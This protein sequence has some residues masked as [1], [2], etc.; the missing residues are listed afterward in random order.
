MVVLFIFIASILSILS[1]IS[2]AVTSTS[3]AVKDSYVDSFYPV[4]NYGQQDWLIFGDYLMGPTEAYIEFTTYPPPTG[5][6]KAEIQIDMYSVI[7]TTELTISLVTVVWSEFTVTW[8]TKP[9]IGTQITT[10]TVS[11]NQTYTIDV[12]NFVTGRT[13]AINI[14]ATSFPTGYVQATSREGNT[15]TNQGPTLIWTH[16]GYGPAIPGFSLLFLVCLMIGACTYII[17]RMKKHPRHL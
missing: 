7:N 14:A 1:P 16:P 6:T 8:A 2:H 13:I 9:A 11:A 3:L 10:L 17:L 15:G 4:T 5:W 12:T